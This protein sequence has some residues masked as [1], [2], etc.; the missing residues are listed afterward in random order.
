MQI[1]TINMPSIYID[2]IGKL[3]DMGLFPSRSEAMRQMVREFLKRELEMIESLLDITEKMDT[4][5]E[6]NKPAKPQQKIDMRAIK[7]GWE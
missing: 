5:I 3:V 2:A 7:R 6:N 1:V 4:N